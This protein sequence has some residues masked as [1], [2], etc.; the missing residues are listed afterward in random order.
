MGLLDVG[1]HRW[2]VVFNRC[3][4][5][6]LIR[7]MIQD[8]DIFRCKVPLDLHIDMVGLSKRNLGFSL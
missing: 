5:P 4:I 2:L 1:D 6:I 3:L 8:D 7:M